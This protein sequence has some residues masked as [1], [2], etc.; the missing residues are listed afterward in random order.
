M[1]ILE[2]RGV[3]REIPGIMDISFRWGFHPDFWRNVQKMAF[4]EVVGISQKTRKTV[5]IGM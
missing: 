5:K 4:S 1:G 3:F 2:K